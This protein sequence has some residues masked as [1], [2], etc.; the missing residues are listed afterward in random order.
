MTEKLTDRALIE[1]LPNWG[2]LV[3]ESHHSPQFTMDWRT[4][5]FLKVVYVLRG[6]G[7]FFI[8]DDAWRFAAG[9]VIVVPP[10]TPNRIVDDP[11]A[12]S[13]LYVCCLST[14]LFGFDLGL[15]PNIEAQHV[16]GDGHFANRVAT[17]MRR[18]VY[19]Q[20][21]R[22]AH[23]ALSMVADAMQLTQRIVE[24]KW[25]PQ[26]NRLG[27]TRSTELAVDEAMMAQYVESLKTD[28]FE[29]STIDAAA[30]NLGMPRRTF[31]KLFS[32][33][34]GETWLEHVRRLAIDHAKQRLKETS[35]PIAS[36]AFECGFNDLSTF[37]RQFKRQVGRSPAAYRS[38]K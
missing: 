4:H 21:R 18:M 28:F 10:Q 2:V 30:A 17:L 22:G 23:C 13:S 37:Y 11:A 26:R 27:K 7:D 34:T 20:E 29:T 24:P 5:K 33:A 31:T 32:Q 6:F 8:G 15:I 3:L 25:S 38:D 12:A 14:S 16:R 36:V 1:T 35:L 19:T 9:D